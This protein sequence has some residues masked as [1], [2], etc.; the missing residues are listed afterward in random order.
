MRDERELPWLVEPLH[1]LRDDTRGHALILQ[2]G[3]GSGLFELALRTAQ[4]WLCEQPPGPCDA[5]GSCHLVGAHSHADLRVLMP[6][7]HQLELGWNAGE[8][9]G[10]DGDAAEAKGKRK[11]SKEI[12]VEA[13]RQ[14]IDWAHTSSGR[15][16]GKVLVLFPAD[17][18]NAVSANALLKT[19][20]EPAPGMRILL[21]VEDAQHLLPTLRSRCQ[22]VRLA[23]PPAEQ[24]LAWLAA[25]GIADAQALL[26]SCGGQP[27]AAASAAGRGLTG[28]AWA[29]LPAQVARGQSALLGQLSVPDAIRALQQIC[30]DAMA[31]KAGA[32]PRFFPRDSVPVARSWTVL[33]DWSRA[34]MRAA[35]TEDHPWNAGLLLEALLAQGQKALQADPGRLAGGSTRSPPR[36]SAATLRS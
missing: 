15:G 33:A 30:H 26:Q 28:A 10:A 3:L 6:E 1:A 5:C 2:G 12:R 20:E 14:A 36:S 16:R 27:L 23:P 19:L 7:A 25:Q 17:A 8:G 4:A 29:A 22:M 31:A 34:L 24:A 21:C 11:P 13:V 32:E 35:R 9:E 18:M